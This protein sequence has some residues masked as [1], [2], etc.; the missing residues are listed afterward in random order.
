M[1]LEN[2]SCAREYQRYSSQKIWYDKYEILN[3]IEKTQL[4]FTAITTN[5]RPQGVFSS[6]FKSAFWWTS[7]NRYHGFHTLAKRRFFPRFSSTRRKMSVFKPCLQYYFATG[8]DT[9]SCEDYEEYEF[10]ECVSYNHISFL[11]TRWQLV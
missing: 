3:K 10:V 8:S 5:T 6:V 11:N 1:W 2:I 9:A 7:I 4:L